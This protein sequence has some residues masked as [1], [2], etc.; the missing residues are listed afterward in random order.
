MITGRL[1]A[2]NELLD[3]GM[4]SGQSIGPLPVVVVDGATNSPAG[5]HRNSAARPPLPWEREQSLRDRLVDSITADDPSGAPLLLELDAVE[6]KIEAHLRGKQAEQTL[7]L[8][9]ELAEINARGKLGVEKAM[10]AVEASNVARGAYNAH[11]ELAARAQRELK[12]AKAPAEDDF[13]DDFEIAEH[14]ER[15]AEIRG[16][17]DRTM[18]ES[19]RLHAAMKSAET[20]AKDAKRDVDAIRNRRDELRSQLSGKR[21]SPIASLGPVGLME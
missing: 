11:L 13:T 14:A 8:K 3:G 2:F 20:A 12:Q 21:Q 19:K 15:L 4:F 1:G 7:D 9:A 5:F 18:Q 10:A 16:A 6:K 17:H